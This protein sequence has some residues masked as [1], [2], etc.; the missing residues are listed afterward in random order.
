MMTVN[1]R[2]IYLGGITL[3]AFML[4]FGWLTC[5]SA[6]Y[7]IGNWQAVSAGFAACGALWMVC[8][9]TMMASGIGLAAT[10]G[11]KTWLLKLGGVATCVSGLVLAGGA[12]VHAIPCAGP[13]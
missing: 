3:A 13:S 4:V 10:A 6:N 2:K 5:V 9:P 12:W 7:V 8:G 11:G 1:G